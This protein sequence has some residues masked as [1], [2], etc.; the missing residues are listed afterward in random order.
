M[1]WNNNYGEDPEKAVFFHCSNFPCSFLKNPKMDFQT[2]IAGTVGKENTFGT[3]QGRIPP[4]PFTF[5]RVSTDDASG[6]ILAY[7][8]E[9]A[10]TDDPLQTFGGYGVAHIAGLQTLL[11]IMC[12]LGFEHH[13]AVNLSHCAHV[14]QEA[15]GHYLGWNVYHH[16]VE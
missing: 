8:G 12:K 3:C 16:L 11:Q 15:L 7:F 9:G 14:L 10:F 6:E 5:L 2:I 4:G 1:D 13:V